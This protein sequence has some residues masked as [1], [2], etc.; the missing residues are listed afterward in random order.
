MT[1]RRSLAKL[2]CTLALAVPLIAAANPLVALDSAVF[3]ERLVPNKG[4]LLQ[5]ASVLKPGDRLVYV[6]SWYR[7]GGQGGFTVTNPLPRKVYFQ[8]SA[9]GRE[10]VSIDGGR[11]W[12]KLD[13]LRVGTR[14]A[15]PED[16]THVRWRVPATEAARG[17]GQITY[18]AIVR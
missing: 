11:S 17:S 6:V 15:T 13:A 12:G 3:V 18:S 4:R 9:D 1:I 10:E 8:G 7:M 16:I 14:L 5:P 2:A